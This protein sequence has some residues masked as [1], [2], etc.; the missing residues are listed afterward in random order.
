[1]IKLFF[2]LYT[3]FYVF[4][5]KVVYYKQIEI[6]GR[7][8]ANRFFRIELSRNASLKILGIIDLKENVLIAVRKDASLTIGSNCFFNRNCSI[9]AREK[10]DIGSDCMFGESIKIYDNN[11]LVLGGEIYKD[12]YDTK[13]V[14][15]ENN[16][17]IA[18][19]VNILMGAKI[20][21]NSVV[22]AMSL[23]NSNLEKPGV[24]M[25]IP[26]RYVKELN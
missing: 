10:I 18:N 24:Y 25:G 20:A 9:V 11:H 4:Y 19:D 1:M 2:K 14:I 8:K 6:N 15:I 17:W 13:P 16:C 3:F 23:V 22:A 26:A 5:L 12:K 21:E 7:I